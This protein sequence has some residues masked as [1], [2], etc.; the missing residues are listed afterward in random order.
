M[1]EF[2]VE[3]VGVSPELSSAKTDTA[4]IDDIDKTAAAAADISLFN[5]ILRFPP[6]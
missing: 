2:G 3:S 5:F 6:A 1:R 4:D